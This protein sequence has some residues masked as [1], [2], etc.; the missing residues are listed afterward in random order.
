MDEELGLES[1]LAGQDWLE[2]RDGWVY[3][4]L[5]GEGRGAYLRAPSEKGEEYEHD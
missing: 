3:N 1:Q 4:K 5:N 2:F